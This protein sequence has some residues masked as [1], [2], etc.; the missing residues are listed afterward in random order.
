MLKKLRR[1]VKQFVPY[2]VQ[3]RY[4]A[5]RYGFREG[6]DLERA[7]GACARLG[8]ALRDSLPYGLVR[9]LW[10]EPPPDLV[11]IQAAFKRNCER[12][13][14]R[15]RDGK[16]LRAVFLVSNASMFPALPLFSA[17]L[18]DSAFSPRVLVVPD[19]RWWGASPLPAM[20]RCLS[21]LAPLVPERL[22]VAAAPLRDG[23]WPDLLDDADIVCYQSP[24]ELSDWHYNPRFSARRRF[25]PIMVNY[26]FYRSL[27]DRF[28]MRLPSYAYMWMALFECS[29]T[30]REYSENSIVHGANGELVGY[31][32]MD[33]LAP[34]RKDALP[35][36][37]GKR[38]TLLVAL[39]HSLAGGQNDTLIL[40]AFLRNA[41]FLAS[42]PDRY[43]QVDFIFRPHPF[44]LKMLSLKRYWGRE[45]TRKYFGEL[46]SKPN[47]R[48][49]DGP[50][51]FPDFEASDAILQD[52]GSYLVEYLYTLKPCCYMLNSPDDRE[53]LFSP[54]GQRC[55]DVCQIAC[56]QK[57][58]AR[59]MEET[60]IG[61][62][63]AL[64]E[65]RTALAAEVMLNHP[66]ASQT[67][68][69]RILQRIV[70]A[71]RALAA[72]EPLVDVL[73]A[74]HRPDPTFLGEQ[75]AS[76]SA[77]VGVRVNLIERED[78]E[79]KGACANF[80]A[81]L[82]A[83]TAP[84]VA[85][86]DQDDVWHE[87]TLM[88]S[89]AL[90]REMESRYGKSTPLA[91]YTD[92]VVTDSSLREISPSLFRH[93][94]ID[95][96]RT[97]PRQLAFQNVANGNTMLINAAL[98]NLAR[99]IPPE[100][101]MHDHWLMLV[102]ASFGHVALLDEPTLLYRQH[103][104]NAIGG[105]RVDASYFLARLADGPNRLRE[106]LYANVRQADAFTRRFGVR[107]PAALRALCGLELLPWPRRAAAI[108]RHRIFK[109]GFLRNLGTLFIV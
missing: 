55:L 80:A 44:L 71:G 16:P 84:Y 102:A 21:S 83:S 97:E 12:C 73:M 32:K 92:A 68:L 105:A 81:L 72:D 10:P 62:R 61:G 41:D 34:P 64:R 75:R 19:L 33:R 65:K 26:G 4:A 104:G 20:E 48:W 63:D 79:E 94:R 107:T 39:H 27:Y 22:L 78:V 76:I 103:G 38:P 7:G 30:L 13:A 98:R 77:Q 37:P 54:L 9:L 47:V 59:F 18:R 108:L 70:D 40:S 91:V 5:R 24:Y 58:I 29:E 66:H 8:R 88:R 53:R 31:V 99:P 15:L 109:C 11:A 90:M 95:P 35:R 93:T 36:Q 56:D 45:K 106:R 50:D 51:Y 2:G 86:A 100:A 49:S 3:S 28:V 101:F 67:A 89:L 60:V 25:L 1:I 82:D 96:R 85:F 69:W 43:P 23:S 74:T 87:D 46:R 52:C 14:A 42:L 57:A 6:R 17:M